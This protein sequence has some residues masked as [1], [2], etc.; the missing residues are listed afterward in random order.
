MISLRNLCKTFETSGG[1]I[2]VLNN[3]SLD[4]KQGEI[5]GIIG[6]SGAGKSTLVRC[7]NL[8]EKPTSGEIIFDGMNMTQLNSQQLLSVRQSMSMVF[9]SF[10]LLSQ[11]TPL[12]NVCYP[13]EIANVPKAE[14]RKRA[15]ELLEACWFVRQTKCLSVPI[16]WRSKTKSCNSKG[17]GYKSKGSAL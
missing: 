15:V 3:I 8:L 14:A 7:I 2:E 13:L 5:F 1:T 11:R 17:I 10:N 6:L 9:Q 16:V 12:K 4:I